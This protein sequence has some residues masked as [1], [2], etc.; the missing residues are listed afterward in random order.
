MP[1]RKRIKEFLRP[2]SQRGP[3]PPPSQPSSSPSPTGAQL[4][5]GN[6]TANFDSTSTQY[7]NPRP[8]APVP[9]KSEA[10]EIA[11]QKSVD[12][13]S[14]DDKIAFRSPSDIMERLLAMQREQNSRISSSLLPRVQN[15]LQCVKYFMGSTVIFI[16]H[17]P[18][19]SSLV[20][21]GLNCILTV[22]MVVLC[23]Y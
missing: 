21:G 20:I 14:D 5:G 12:N 9:A 7:L 3:S 23:I 6:T 16:Q 10:F 18:E 17:S 2:K 19:I 4:A 11:L 8:P 13:L 1:T 22:S 15:V